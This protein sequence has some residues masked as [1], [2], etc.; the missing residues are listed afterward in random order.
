MTAYEDGALLKLARQQ[1]GEPE[2]FTSIQ[3]EGASIGRP[4]TFVRLSLCNLACSWCDTRYT[5]DWSHF[6]PKVEIISMLSSEVVERV[7]ALGVENVVFSGGEP[8]VQQHELGNVAI[9]LAR[10]GHRIEV[11][12]NGTYIPTP[13]LQ[14][15]VSQWNVSPKLGNSG[16]A[17]FRRLPDAPLQWFAQCPSAWFKFVVDGPEDLAEIEE[18]TTRYAIPSRSVMLMPQGTTA[19]SLNRRSAW[20]ADACSRLGYGFSPRLHILLWGDVRGR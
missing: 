10:A 16:N 6:D 20:L 14:R 12:T 11:E 5:W 19:D 13:S 9:R 7:S 2:I 17:P 8:L 18:I 3:G 4:S 15:S 1:T